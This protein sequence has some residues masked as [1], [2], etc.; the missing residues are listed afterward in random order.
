M[1]SVGSRA[2]VNSQTTIQP[3]I[4]AVST[5]SSTASTTSM[6]RSN[7]GPS[8]KR[9]SAVGLGSLASRTPTSQRPKSDSEAMG[10]TYRLV[11]LRLRKTST[12]LEQLGARGARSIGC[13]FIHH[14]MLPTT[15]RGL[16]WAAPI[17][18]NNVSYT[19]PI[20]SLHLG[21]LHVYLIHYGHDPGNGGGSFMQRRVHNG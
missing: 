13:G 6:T 21:S 20:S 10:P 5:R 15:T 11:S 16:L 14:I 17:D 8:S 18:V 2:S 12:W 7:S 9:D 1:S 3:L 19:T 4:L